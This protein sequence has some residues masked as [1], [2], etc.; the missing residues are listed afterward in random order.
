[1]SSCYILTTCVRVSIYPHIIMLI[2]LWLLANTRASL[3]YNLRRKTLSVYAILK[4]IFDELKTLLVVCTAHIKLFAS[5]SGG[6][7]AFRKWRKERTPLYYRVPAQK[8]FYLPCVSKSTYIHTHT[9]SGCLEHEI[10]R[11]TAMKI[12]QLTACAVFNIA[13]TRHS[14]SFHLTG[15]GSVDELSKW[16]LILSTRLLTK[17]ILISESTKKLNNVRTRTAAERYEEEEN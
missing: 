11:A 7:L 12:I 8:L 4:N 17:T 1:M 6:V 10:I 2:F 5:G 9:F 14:F 15:L 13:S 3:H 16:D